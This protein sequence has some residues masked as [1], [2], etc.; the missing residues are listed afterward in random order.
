[1]PSQIQSVQN[2][3]IKPKVN[4]QGPPSKIDL[5]RTL[6][7][8]KAGLNHEEIGKVFGVSGS[9]VCQQINKYIT[10]GI[11]LDFY[12]QNRA[13]IFASKQAQILK[14]L[15]QRKIDKASAYQMTGMLGILY[16]KERL[17]RGQSTANVAYADMNRDAK[18]MEREIKRLQ[19]ELGY[20]DN[21]S[22]DLVGSG[23]SNDNNGL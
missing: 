7:M 2:P 16:D 21:G 6:V 11:D 8:I 10:D 4:H 22:M 5:N 13:D 15:S 20:E 14:S 9:A 18:E 3:L 17:E 19:D 12:K 1:M 23:D